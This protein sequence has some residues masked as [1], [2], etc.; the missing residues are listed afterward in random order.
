MLWPMEVA[1]GSD[2]VAVKAAYGERLVPVG[3][4]DQRALRQDRRAVDRE[5][6]RIRPTYEMG[7]YIPCA[8]G[9]LGDI[10]WDTFAHYLNG[11]GHLVGKA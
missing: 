9:M 4:I 8:D 1:P 5:I 3:G 11:L 7:G 2:V 6:E 10:S